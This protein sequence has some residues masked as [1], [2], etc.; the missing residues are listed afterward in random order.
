MAQIIRE[1]HDDM[2]IGESF[3]AEETDVPV[4]IWCDPCKASYPVSHIVDSPG[5]P[6]HGQH[7]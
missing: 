4:Q 1:F 3:G 7:F 6:K 5:H 2:P